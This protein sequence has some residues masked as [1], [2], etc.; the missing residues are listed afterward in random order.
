MCE[1][2]INDDFA[3]IQAHG[4]GSGTNY[5]SGGDNEA[6]DDNYSLGIWLFDGCDS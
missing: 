3:K 1:K 4:I 2:T 5:K 6:I